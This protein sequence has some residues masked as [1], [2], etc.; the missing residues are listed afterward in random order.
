VKWRNRNTGQVFEDKV[1]LRKRMP[2]N[3]E[4]P[5]RSQRSVI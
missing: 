2:R 3:I 1:D 4:G 5:P